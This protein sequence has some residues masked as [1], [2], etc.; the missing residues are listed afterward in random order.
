MDD[1]LSDIFRLI[2]LT[3]CVYFRRDFHAP[4]AMRMEAGP[5]AQFH[6][7]TRG[8]C[9]VELAQGCHELGVGDVVLFP[10]GSGHT[11]A[12][13]PGRAAVPGPQVMASLAGSEP[14]FSNGGRATGLICGHYAY[15]RWPGHP[16]LEALPDC[17]LVRSL[18]VQPNLA[19]TSVLPLLM[20]ELRGEAPGGS[21]IVERLAEVL[22]IQVLRA[23]FDAGPQQ[24]G[25]LAGLS[26][27]RLVRAI[28]RMHLQ[29]DAPLTLDDLAREAG[30]SRSVFAQ[31]F[32]ERTGM[33]PIE[34]LT[35][36]RML[37]ASD[38][39]L[40]EDLSLAQIASRVGYESDIAFARAFKREFEVSPSVFRRSRA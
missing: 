32:K 10:R 12:D 16:A 7:V 13:Q 28:R 23:H 26:D 21:A 20:R 27:S 11:L 34:Y 40:K 17:I 33:S 9:V 6:V 14:L 31:R 36:W 25:F 24:V 30:M 5:F 1:T 39:L 2:Q 38:L 4:W 3:S 15:R 8:D 29:A 37:T 19:A 18:E 22:L 35:R